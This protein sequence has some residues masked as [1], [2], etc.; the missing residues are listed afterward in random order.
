LTLLVGQLHLSRPP[1]SLVHGDVA[2][3]RERPSER[4]P[5]EEEA[6]LVAAHETEGGEGIEVSD[7]LFEQDLGVV[8]GPWQFAVEQ[9]THAQSAQEHRLEVPR[10]Y[11]EDGRR[12]HVAEIYQ[13]CSLLYLP[14]IQRVV[15]V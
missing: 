5:E 13:R 1:R 3:R 7:G 9:R 2:E 4:M 11:R 12:I 8:L 14:F 15:V 10:P 6:L